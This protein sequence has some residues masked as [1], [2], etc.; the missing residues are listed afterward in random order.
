MSYNLVFVVPLFL[1]VLATLFIGNLISPKWRKT[2]FSFQPEYRKYIS[3]FVLVALLSPSELPPIPKPIEFF[4]GIAIGVALLVVL[5]HRLNEAAT[6]KEPLTIIIAML[7]VLAILFTADQG[8]TG[9]KVLDAIGVGLTWL[10][11]A[12]CTI[13]DLC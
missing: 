8:L 11:T 13:G 10:L 4:M 2:M 3:G 1:V 6:S 5:W 9:G 7:A 12:G